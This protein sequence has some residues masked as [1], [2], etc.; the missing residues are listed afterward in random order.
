M[1][2]SLK[3]IL[4]Q[5]SIYS[6]G[7]ALRRIVGFILIPLYTHYLTPGDYGVLEIL[8]LLIIM[9]G[10]LLGL[11]ALGGSMV[12]IYYDYNEENKKELVISTAIW[13]A[14]FVCLLINVLGISFSKYISK[15]LFKTEDYYSL[16]VISFISLFFSTI[17]EIFFLK[18]QIENKA[19]KFVIISTISLLINIIL[20]IIFIAAYKLGVA[21]FIYSKIFTYLVTFFY[22][23]FT[24]LKNKKAFGLF[25]NGSIAKKI[26]YFANSLI[27]IH[28]SIFSIHFSDR[29]LINE[30]LNIYEVGIYSFAYKFAFLLAFFVSQPFKRYWDVN[31]YKFLSLKGWNDEFAKVIYYFW[32]SLVAF[33]LIISLFSD[34]AIKLLAESSYWESMNIVSFLILAYLFRELGDFFKQLF[35]IKKEMFIL[36][37]IVVSVAVFNILL[38]LILIK[39]AGLIG[40]AISKIFTWL[41]FLIACWFKSHK[42]HS[43]PVIKVRLMALLT[44]AVFVYI[45]AFE[46][47]TDIFIIDLFM[48]ILFYIIFLILIWKTDYFNWEDKIK[49]KNSIHDFRL[50]LSR[51]KSKRFDWS[52]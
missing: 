32:F 47:K 31:F 39:K 25:F 13:L 44:I 24:S 40:G 17:N 28:L 42:S 10:I 46:L 33:G 14:V 36:G 49:I 45:A 35:Y 20:N 52:V 19:L 41:L 9:L 1:K 30:F 21:G 4:K 6:L 22:F 26:I 37:S 51:F 2:I 29:Y 43:I 8:D 16:I 11:Q 7:N 5:S 27:I 38:S 18:L 23:C 50:L 48:K 12:R 3:N 34:L 15:I